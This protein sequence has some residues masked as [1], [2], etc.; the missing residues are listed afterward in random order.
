MTYSKFTKDKEKKV[1]SYCYKK[2][3]LTKKDTRE[4]EMKK[5]TKQPKKLIK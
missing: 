4:E 5:E 3:Q 1:K 2:Y